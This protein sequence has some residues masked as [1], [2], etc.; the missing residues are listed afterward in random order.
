[1]SFK[2]GDRK[3]E[4]SGRRKGGQNKSTVE[5]KERIERYGK[6]AI[7]FHY[8]VMTNKVECGVCR[9]SG[10]APFKK[11]E[12]IG[13]RACVSC[14][15]DG[16]ERIDPKTR[17]SSADSLLDRYLPKLKAVE[18]AGP[19]GGPIEV[20]GWKMVIVETEEKI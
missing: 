7:E 13:R 17:Q 10:K 4:T 12:G 18:H 14:G 8:D 19:G 6:E 11:G 16:L 15:G 3:P 20:K 1:M 2:K 9:G 5:G